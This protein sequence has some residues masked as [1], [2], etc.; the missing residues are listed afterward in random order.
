MS[1]QGMGKILSAKLTLN[2]RRN[3]LKNLSMTWTLYSVLKILFLT[4]I[5]WKSF[6]FQSNLNF[7]KMDHFY[8]NKRKFLHFMLMKRSKRNKLNGFLTTIKINFLS[9][10]TLKI[11][12]IK[13]SS[14]KIIKLPI[15]MKRL[16][17]L[18]AIKWRLA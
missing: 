3:S 1:S 17:L 4:L 13:F 12:R 9:K 8:F 7:T 10:L 15:S 11:H 18:W 5:Y 6:N 16:K 14:S 2:A